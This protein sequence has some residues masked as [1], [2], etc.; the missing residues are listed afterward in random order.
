MVLFLP[1][2]RGKC[3][4]NIKDNAFDNFLKGFACYLLF[5]SQ[6]DIL[7]FKHKAEKLIFLFLMTFSY[8][9]KMSIFSNELLEK[10]N[11]LSIKTFKTTISPPSWHFT[12]FKL[13]W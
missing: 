5:C 2:Q 1:N 12:T 10:I 4:A 8:D 11:H 6:L 9:E 13:A 3:Q 7:F